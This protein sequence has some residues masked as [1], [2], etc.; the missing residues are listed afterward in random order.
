VNWAR[1]FRRFRGRKFTQRQLALALGI[2][3]R[4]VIYIEQGEREPRV[5]T[6]EKFK[7]LQEKH[8]IREADRRAD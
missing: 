1:E 7:A 2:S 4:A 3:R 5:R 8:A 6:V